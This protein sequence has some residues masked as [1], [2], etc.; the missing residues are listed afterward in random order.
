MIALSEL[1]PVPADR[2]MPS[3]NASARPQGAAILC[4]V[5]H[6]TAG[7]DL[8]AEA[9]MLDPASRVSAHL[10]IRRNGSVTRLV[11]DQRAAWH[12]GASEWKGKTRVNDFSLG[13]EIANR[14]DGKEAYTDAQY[15]T[16]ATLA[17]HY[18]RQ[19]LT[20][21]EFVSHE[22]IARPR[23]RKNDPL[24]FDWPRFREAVRTQL[25]PAPARPA[26]E[27]GE[28]V[29]SRWAG[30]WLYPI[31]PESDHVWEFVTQSE[32]LGLPRR[33]AYTPLSQMPRHP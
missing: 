32:I 3:P 15:A 27:I 11:A 26:L 21:A 14:N 1:A 18:I 6:A 12:A 2:H 16:L 20:I 28:P 13:W 17:A 23:G 30:D 25:Q 33:R 29:Y 9:W 10:H 7:T 4:V 24:G 19:G 22:E 8:G 31:R 5:L